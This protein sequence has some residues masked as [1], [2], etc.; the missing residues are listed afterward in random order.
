MFALGPIDMVP[1]HEY[2]YGEVP[3]DTETLAL[4]FVPFRQVE[5]VADDEVNNALG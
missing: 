4:P 1:V 5:G 3:P 2:E